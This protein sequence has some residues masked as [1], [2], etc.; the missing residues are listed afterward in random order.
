MSRST[1][2]LTNS[3]SSAALYVITFVAGFIIP[4]IMLTAYGS[5]ING[6]VTSIS[7]FVGYFN[8]VEAGLA[9]CAVYALYGP[10]SAQDMKRVSAIVSASR[11][12]YNTSGYV[13]VS[14]V[15][16]LAAIYPFFIR[17]A[18][19][20]RG[21]VGILVLA[22][23][24][25]GAMEFFTMS[26]YRVLLTA[27]QRIYVLSL[28]SICAI[29][30][31][32]A[33]V[34]V[35]AKFGVSIV[36]VRI[37]ALSAVFIRSIILWLYVRQKYSNVDYYAAPDTY[38]LKNRWDALFLQILGSVHSGA[39]VIIA[40]V[41]TSLV[42]V[43]VYSIYN[44]V[45]GGIAGLLSVAITGLFASFGDVIVRKEKHVLQE[46]YQEFELIYYMLITWVYACSFIL[47]MPFIRLYTRNITDVNYDVPLIGVLF[48]ANGLM[49]NIKTPQGMLV[50]SAGLFKET[51]L[52]TA[53]QGLIAVFGGILFVQFW[54]VA[55]ILVG[56]ILSNVYR[57]VD[58]LFFVPRNITGLEV[59]K[60]LYRMC[61]IFIC[62]VVAIIPF[63][64]VTVRIDSYMAWV[65]YAV[66]T[67][68]YVSIVVLL[69][70][71]VADRATLVNAAKRLLAVI[72]R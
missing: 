36:I 70:N 56:S 40:T 7:Q 62:F 14:L 59:R 35:L 20:S 3:V 9:T 68:A 46:A 58:L 71:V 18:S 11:R 41:F 8:L 43:S 22:V 33:I 53:I 16:A 27:D 19:L 30:L 25:T 69:G 57:D 60:T 47:I 38:A 4:R 32:T 10:L 26:K 12:L 67:G 65:K 6:L 24:C 31:N 1:A 64:F 49:Y 55:G 42:A 23:G 37:V 34:A 45:L 61:R 50:I 29:V 72:S 52:Q 28:G 48:V 63:Q 39:P 2:F 54:G 51:R 21:E 44:A 5:E 17:S 15:V 13:F 66:A